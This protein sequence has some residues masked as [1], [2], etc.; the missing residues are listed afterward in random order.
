LWSGVEQDRKKGLAV[1]SQFGPWLLLRALTRTISVS[2]AL[3]KA[4][5]RL[6]L[7][8][9]P[10]VMSQAE[11]VIDVDKPADLVLAESILRE[12]ELSARP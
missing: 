10:I 11:A 9:K 3:A 6:G 8:A 4:G 1:I 5:R 7:T 12:R 2:Q